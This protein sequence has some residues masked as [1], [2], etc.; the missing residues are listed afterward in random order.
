MK[1]RGKMRTGETEVL[2]MIKEK[3]EVNGSIL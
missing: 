3:K 2:D 1:K